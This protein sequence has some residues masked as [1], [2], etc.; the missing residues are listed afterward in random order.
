M[1]SKILRYIIG[2]LLFFLIIGSGKA[3]EDYNGFMITPEENGISGPEAS[4][5]TISSSSQELVLKGIVYKNSDSWV[6]WI[7]EYCLRSQEMTM[8]DK[9]EFK[10]ERVS[11]DTVQITKKGLTYYLST[12]AH[13]FPLKESSPQPL[14]SQKMKEQNVPNEK[15]SAHQ[16][17]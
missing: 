3:D 2:V 11:S 5:I 6:V 10:I 1:D 8:W 16:A 7:N 9:G 12:S 15:Q 13:S 14:Q 4:E 17:K